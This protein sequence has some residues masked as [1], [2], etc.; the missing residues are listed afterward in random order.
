MA[1]LCRRYW[2]PLYAYVRRRGHNAD[3][4][5]DF[6]Q[7]FFVYL[8]EQKLV[9]AADA[10][11][12]KFR[13]YL[14]GSLRNYLSHERAAAGRRKRGGGREILPL[15]LS[16]AEARYSCEPS[17]DLTPDKIFD[18]QWA[19]TVLELAMEQLE[20]QAAR[21]G[22]HRQFQRLKHCLP[23]VEGDEY[24]RAAADLEMEEGAVRVAVHRL[25]RR[26]RELIE[27]QIRRT[28]E[29][30]GEIDDEVRHLLAAVAAT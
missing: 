8:L 25:R 10:R 2:F 12:G 16:G 3:Q 6:T 27:E 30:P 28:V 11:R 22:K 15:D 1:T 24:Q 14:L 29:F 4:A 18:R 17:H 26:Y 21:S 9:R 13:S 5:A 19:L 20:R 23:G 7:G